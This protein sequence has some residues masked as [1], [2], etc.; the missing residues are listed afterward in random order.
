MMSDRPNILFILTDQH[1]LSGLGCYEPN[2]PCQTPHLDRLARE[3]ILF[4]N[5]YTPCPVCTPTR[6]SILTGEFPHTHGMRGNVSCHNI[7]S[8]IMRCRDDTLAY[9]LGRLGYSCG[10]NGKWHMGVETRQATTDIIYPGFLP[11]STGFE[12]Y[13]YPG[14]GGGGHGY[15]DYKRFLQENG[16]SHE[17]I[18]D[19]PIAEELSDRGYGRITGPLES[20]IPYYLGT[21]TI[22]LMEDFRS[23]RKPW[24]IWHSF[25]GPHEPY[26][27][28]GEFLDIYRNV[29]I[30]PWDT[31][32][33]EFAQMDMPHA[34]KR[35]QH[36]ERIAWYHWEE[37]LRHYYAFV[38]LIDHQIGR[39][40][41]YL[42]ESGQKENTVLVFA[43]DHGE[44][45]GSHAGLSD[46]G[47]H[48]FEEIQRVPLILWL[49]ETL[50]FENMKNGQRVDSL[51]SLCDLF[52]TFLDL[53][54]EE[55]DRIGSQGSSLLPLVEDPECAWR[56][57]V[58]CEFWAL[59]GV[60][61]N[62]VSI[63]KGQFKYGW[64]G[65]A[66]DELY[67][68]QEDPNERS[69]LI[70][71]RSHRD[72]LQRL[73]QRM[74]QWMDETDMPSPIRKHFLQTSRD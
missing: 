38:T 53:A 2:T 69:N 49:P 46:K 65:D 59:A 15:P 41:E 7:D 63:R 16:W 14:H 72:V 21:H 61:T 27:A 45:L 25:W 29:S 30:P 51:V 66:S 4:Q 20:T 36:Y 48:H 28:T 9:R 50:R 70:Q 68:L 74:L 64:N 52:P 17:V 58:A 32:S 3:G 13:D 71:S 5:A 10:Y 44:T 57:A 73:R 33:S 12:G 40:I 60:Y 11:S 56:D 43:A 37:L 47:W 62:M 8:Q 19:R 67:D 54:G 42:E 23:R 18:K 24:F 6:A 26:Y 39:L 31:F 55:K 34:A 1:R 35:V 22:Q